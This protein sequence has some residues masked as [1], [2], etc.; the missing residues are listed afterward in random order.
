[1]GIAQS[2]TTDSN[3]GESRRRKQYRIVF[4]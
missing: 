4:L 1:M 3:I 2:S